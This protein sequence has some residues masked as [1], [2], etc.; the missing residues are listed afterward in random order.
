MKRIVC[1]LLALL[2]VISAF[3]GCKWFSR[4]EDSKRQTKPEIDNPYLVFSLTDEMVDDFYALLEESEALAIAA[5]DLELTDQVSDELEDA[6]LALVDQYQIAYVLYCLDQKDEEAKT[7][8]LDCVDL[9]TEA[10][11]AYNDMCKRVWLSETPF[12]D[13]LFEDWTEDEIERMLA[14]N[15]EIAQLEKRNSEITVEYRELATGWGPEMIPLYNEMVQNNNRIAEIYGYENYYVY[16]YDVVY[17]RDYEMSEIEKMRRYAASYLIDAH[18]GAMDTFMELYENMDEDGSDFLS[19]Y[20]YED[21]DTLEENYVREY[22]NAL[23]DSARENMESM[24]SEDRVVF[25]SYKNAYAGAF[26]TWIGEEPFCFFGPDYANSET[27]IHELGHYYGSGFAEAWA[28]PMDLAETQ[29]QGN[30]WL[31]THFMQTQLDADVYE[32]LTAYKLLTDLGYIVCFIM[33]DEFEQQVYSHENAGNLTED[34]YDAIMEEIA[35]QYGGIDYVTENMLDVQT[36]WRQVVLESPVYYISYA[37][38][39]ITA[40]N[41][42]TMA[43]E[44]EDAAIASYIRLQ[45]EPLEDAGFLANIRYAGINGPFDKS[46]YEKLCSRYEK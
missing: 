30:E 19:H 6:Y 2:M 23:P 5:E 20:I 14:Y 29:S 27:V 10:D 22:L 11:A 46:V 3:S 36:Y 34:E 7:R 16:A 13:H 17:E 9:F 40:I 37:V 12:R 44:D 41:L 31:F 26:T 24:F 21:Y 1:I 39:G 25:T 15:D 33:V 45:E 8:Y 18:A 4:K 42:F 32:C 28:Q 38:S 43:Q 35:Q